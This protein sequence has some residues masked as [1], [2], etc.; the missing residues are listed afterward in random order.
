MIYELRTYTTPIGKAPELARLSADIGRGI[1]KDDYGK[2][3]GYWLTEIGPLNQVVHLWSYADLNARLELRA[4]LGR[5]EDWRTR[6][7]PV[8]SPLILR[9]DVRLMHAVKPP[10]AP[11]GGGHVYEYRFYRAKVGKA[12]AFAESLR[13]ALTT[14]DKYRRNVGI[15]LTEAGSPNEVS[16]L[17]AYQSLNH[18]A[19]I[20]LA[21][22]SDPDW[23]TF[24]ATV[25][26]MIEE[27]Q[28]I[29]LL[30]WAHSPMQ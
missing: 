28:S 12:R 17:W 21:G 15:W 27:M 7:L 20:R 29:I 4:A 14:P 13:D 9:Q 6:Y 18:R 3:E 25:P 8:A 10:I 23:R 5:H 2:L 26:E 19:E 11:E 30:P 22:R 24:L 1:R 16:H